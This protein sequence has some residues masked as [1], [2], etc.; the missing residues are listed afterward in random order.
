MPL[1]GKI[2]HAPPGLW[3]F[4]CNQILNAEQCAQLKESFDFCLRYIPRTEQAN[5]GASNLTLA[6]AEIILNAGLSLMCVQHVSKDNWDPTGALGAEYGAYA[7]QY[8]KE[9]VQAPPGF[10]VFLDLEMVNPASKAEDIIAYAQQWYE[11]LYQAGFVPSL[12][13][14]W[15]SGLS[16]DQLY[17]LSFKNY[18]SAYNNDTPVATRGFQ[19]IQKTQKSIVGIEIDPNLTQAD[20]LGD[21]VIFLAPQ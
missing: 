8:L 15:Q 18:W 7:V 9:I 16:A 3:G 6:E 1:N 13:V 17:S 21:S 14:G 2:Q 5:V 12:Y 19:M 10:C 20:H 4:D 11:A